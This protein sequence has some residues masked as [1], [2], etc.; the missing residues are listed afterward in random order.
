MMKTRRKIMIMTKSMTM[1]IKITNY[2]I[3]EN[4]NGKDKVRDEWIVISI[5]EI[6]WKIK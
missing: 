4:D 6:T 2:T 5:C 1:E 3:V